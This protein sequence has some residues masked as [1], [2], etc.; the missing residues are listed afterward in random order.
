[1]LRSEIGQSAALRTVGSDRVTQLLTDLRISPETPLD[2]ATL[3]TLGDFS[4]AQVVISGSFV[5][6]GTAIRLDADLR[7]LRTNQ[8]VPL[9][10][11]APNQAGLVPSLGE[12]ARA[13]HAGLALPENV[14]NEL[15]ATAAR[16]S[17]QSLVALR[18]YNEGVALSRQNKYSEALKLFEASTQE[19][20]EFALAYSKLAEAYKNLRY[21]TEAESFSRRASDLSAGLPARER[22]LIQAAHAR[23]LGDNAKAIESYEQLLKA[24]PED[25]DVRFELARLY[26]DN[27]EY[28]RAREHYGRVLAADPRNIDALLGAGRVEIRLNQPQVALE[29]LDTAHSLAVRFGNDEARG[30]ILNAIGVAYRRMNR[31][32]DALAKYQEALELRRKLGQQ[33]GIASSLTEMANLYVTMGKV[34][35]ALKYHQ[36]ALE[37]RRQIGDKRGI[38]STLT[39]LGN[40]RFSGS[41]YEE[42]LDYYGQALPLLREFKDK[43]S[44]GVLLN[45]IGSAY[46]NRAQ[47]ELALTYFELAVNVREP[48][49]VPAD[50]AQAL[51]N[52]AEVNVKLGQYDA[53]LPR[54]VKELEL[55][56]SIG[57][58]R[59]IALGSYGIG[60]L[61]E[62]QGAFQ[63]AFKSKE[64]ALNNFRELGDEGFWMAEIVSGYGRALTLL[65]RFAEARK[66]LDEALTRATTLKHQ[67]LIAQTLNFQGDNAFLPGDVATARRLF[68][69]ALEVAVKSGDR[70][71]ILLTRVNVAK[72]DATANPPAAVASLTKLSQEAEREGLRYLA[73]DASIYLGEA[74]LRLKRYDE[75][76]QPLERAL[77][78]SERL[79]LQVL[80]ARSHHALATLFDAQRN[81]A[82]AGRHRS[83]AR[84][85]ID[86]VEKESGAAAVTRR[87]DLNPIRAAAAAAR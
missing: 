59:G 87:A 30:S 79:D 43:R 41:E 53:A 70:H 61:L 14:E 85:L 56:R 66:P 84:R 7:D 26:E 51:H 22:F 57:D 77:R 48:L 47:Y 68:A 27:S 5:R 65:G 52:L 20:P 69:E 76:R 21:D 40:L 17:S 60:T 32:E 3:R 19:D 2:P 9:T 67:V 49:N 34:P 10:V 12:L 18:Y 55:Y 36:E 6:L 4:N 28:A 73:A 16:P 8:S 54:Y 72:A 82:E 64:E 42:A 24:S 81:A 23:I 37:I 25:A 44:E 46:F 78:S 75:A 39:A 35:D 71:L 63:R 83:Q 58:K 29:H 15:L 50:T 1:M 86:E 38:A 31:P 13:I 74:L 11:Q 62:Y 80:A 45:N 33:A